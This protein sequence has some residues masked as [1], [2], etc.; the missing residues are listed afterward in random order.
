MTRRPLLVGLAGAALLAAAVPAAAVSATCTGSPATCVAGV[1]VSVTGL[2]GTRQFSVEDVKGDDLSALD[3][4]TG[5]AQPF[6]THVNDSAF[7]ATTQ[8]YSVS[9]SMTNL[10]LRQGNAH[11]YAVK[12][13]SSDVSIGFGGNPL[14]GKGINVVDLPKLLVG[15]TL[16]SCGSLGSTLQAALGLSGAGIP[17]DLSNLQLVQLCGLLAGVD[18]TVSATVDGTLQSVTPTLTSLLDLPTPLSGALGGT[19]TNPSFA[20]GTVGAGDPAAGQTAATSVPLM[21]G[22]ALALSAGLKT[23]LTNALN[24]ALAGLPLV[25][26]TDTGTRT[27][28]AALVGAMSSSS[29]QLTSTLGSVVS[30]LPVAKQV[31]VLT[32]LASSLAAPVLGDIASISGDYYA[33]PILKATPTTPVAGT[34][35]GTMVVTFVQS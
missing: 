25:N 32:T 35:D 3:L 31:S 21:S 7:T 10:Y 30:S 1:P 17:L 8:Q 14:A 28:I 18:T 24:T 26:A 15:G 33:F 5:G 27:T 22:G 11:D 16:G 19:F 2:G 34:Y 4:G 6:R 13:P 29:D 20:A 9:A 12:V 23:A